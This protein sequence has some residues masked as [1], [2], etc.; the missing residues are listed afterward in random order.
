MRLLVDVYEA[1]GQTRVGRGPLT[2]C[3]EASVK[4]KLD[5]AGT[6]TLNFPATDDQARTL[7]INERLARVL[8]DEEVQGEYILRELGRGVIRDRDVDVSESGASFVAKG[9][10]S[11]DA[12]TRRTV[13]LQRKYSNQTMS[14]IASDLIG[15][16]PGWSV[17]FEHAGIAALLQSARYAGATVLKALLR[18]VEERGLHLREDGSNANRIEIGAFGQ[19]SGVTVTNIQSITR[20]AHDND[21]VVFISSIHEGES[22]GDLYNRVYPLGAGEGGAALTLRDSTR[23]TPYAIQSVVESD[24][25]TVY[26]IQ[27]TDSQNTYGVLETVVTFKEVG[28][29]A[30]SEDAKTFAANALYDAAVAWMQRRLAPQKSYKVKGVKPRTSLLPGDKIRLVYKGQVWR[31]SV[32]VDVL[33]VDAEFWLLS[34][35]ERVSDSGLSL[36]LEVSSIDRPLKKIADLVAEK[37]EAVDVRN[38]AIA[39]FPVFYSNTWTRPIEAEDTTFNPNGTA[40]IFTINLDAKITDITSAHIRVKTFPL[41][42]YVFHSIPLNYPTSFAAPNNPHQHFLGEGNLNGSYNV[43]EGDNYPSGLMISIN[44]VDRTSELGGPWNS[45]V[46]EP[47]DIV[48]DITEPLLDAPGGLHQPHIITFTCEGR[49]GDISLPSSFT[50]PINSDAASQGVVEMSL[51]VLGSAQAIIP[52]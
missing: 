9:P 28:P 18:L 11:M 30:N 2:A 23:E 35:T 7:L 48:L 51:N 39:T 19:A 25:T 12:L 24:G 44:G 14:A 37:L 17:T 29:V 15:L 47:L 32:A 50:Q 40:A 4:R 36:D 52:G 46:N 26:Y 13:R 21:D 41:V 27:D 45:G 20:E 16:V 49:N 38:L 43:R 34:V 5:G 42:N 3:T 8:F 22:S 31:D 1:D 10:D 6:L 33:D